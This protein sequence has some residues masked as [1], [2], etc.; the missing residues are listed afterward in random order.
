MKWRDVGWVLVA[1]AFGGLIAFAQAPVP[2]PNH[3]EPPKDWFC[4][5][6]ARQVDHRCACKNMAKDQSDPVCEREVEDDSACL[7]FCHKDHCRCQT[8]C[9]S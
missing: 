8:A 4:S 7:V 5:P 9:D 3:E 6:N 2:F 1:L